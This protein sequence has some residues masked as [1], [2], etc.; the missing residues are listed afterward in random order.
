MRPAATTTPAG[1]S[2]LSS[3]PYPGQA[4]ATMVPP[5][6]S[7]ASTVLTASCRCGSN[8]RPTSSNRGKPRASRTPTAWAWTARTPSPSASGSPS[9]CASARSR[10]STMGTSWAATPARSSRRWRCTS[11][12]K[13]RR[14][15]ARSASARCSRPSH[16][17][18]SAVAALASSPAG[19]SVPA[20]SSTGHLARGRRGV[21]VG[22]RLGAVGVR[23][24]RGRHGLLDGHAGSPH[25]EVGVD[26]VLVVG[27]IGG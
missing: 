24:R 25:R 8:G 2:N 9:V 7:A 27:R 23:V 3:L 19:T 18:S 20:A 4:S 26:D 21:P 14:R 13:R 22:R 12:S 17:V 1:R 16:A 10:L 11:R 6:T 15:L 5:S